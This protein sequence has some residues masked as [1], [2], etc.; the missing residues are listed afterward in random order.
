M[1]VTATMVITTIL[2][3]VVSRERLGWAL[4]S[5]IAVTAGFLV[6]DLAFFSANLVK[7]RHGGWFPLVVAAAVFIL[8]TTWRKGR[9]LLQARLRKVLVTVEEFA[10]E[11]RRA[12]PPVVPGTA[13]YLSMIPEVIPASLRHNFD[14]NRVVHERMVLLT[15]VT[16]ETPRIPDEER[17]TVERVGDRCWK[18]VLR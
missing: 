14:Y 17:V 11:V 8:M 6:F 9:H 18:V 13:I 15:V 4:L 12:K 5:A 7:I 10:A 1:A 3:G 16:E 2:A